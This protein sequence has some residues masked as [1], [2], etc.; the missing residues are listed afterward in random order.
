MIDAVRANFT[1]AGGLL[2]RGGVDERAVGQFFLNI[3]GSY[4]TSQQALR[5]YDEKYFLTRDTRWIGLSD[6]DPVQRS[7]THKFLNHVLLTG[8]GGWY[9]RNDLFKVSG[10]LTSS[11]ES[12]A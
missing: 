3:R 8:L 10:A 12:E 11:A 1:T 7:L 4:D 2:S 9:A 6:G 5:Y